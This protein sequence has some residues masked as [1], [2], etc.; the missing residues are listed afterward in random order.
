[1]FLHQTAAFLSQDWVVGQLSPL[2]WNPPLPS[3]E[4]RTAGSEGTERSRTLNTPPHPSLGATLALSHVSED[5]GVERGPMEGGQ[6][7]ST[8]I[9]LHRTVPPDPEPNGTEVEPPWR[10]GDATVAAALLVTV[11]ASEQTFRGTSQPMGRQHFRIRTGLRTQN[12]SH[13]R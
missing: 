1:M 6:R 8:R 5:G 2:T 10:A 9:S 13:L 3:G 7:T 4:T 11:A 12:W